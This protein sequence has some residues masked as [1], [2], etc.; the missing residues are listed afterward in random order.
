MWA[1]SHPWVMI[2]GGLS[3]LG[4]HPHPFARS[5][6]LIS[7]G[8]TR[9]QKAV[10]DLVTNLV[11]RSP[12]RTKK[13]IPKMLIPILNMTNPRKIHWKNRLIQRKA[14]RDS[15]V[16]Q[17]DRFLSEI[18][19]DDR[20]RWISKHAAWLGMELEPIPATVRGSSTTTEAIEKIWHLSEASAK[21]V[22]GLIIIV[23]VEI[24]IVLLAFLI[25]YGTQSDDSANHYDHQAL[26]TLRKRF[27]DE[28]IKR[29]LEKFLDYGRMPPSRK[30][31]LKQREI[32][33]FL[34]HEGFNGDEIAGLIEAFKN[35][36]D[37]H[38]LSR[39]Q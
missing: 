15:L 2:G 11:L 8:F 38:I 5:R 6:N 37:G 29:F 32:R 21:R 30:L 7:G 19:Q 14:Q 34:E 17:R 18:P 23:T 22:V 31:S 36:R 28:I 10:A 1:A 39:E 35:D 12:R 27:S 20:E 4:D 26:K 24:G 16:A 25:R 3:N 9:M 13:W 33:K